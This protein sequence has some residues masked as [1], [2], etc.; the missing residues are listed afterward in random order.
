MNCKELTDILQHNVSYKPGV[1]FTFENAGDRI[2]AHMATPTEDARGPRRTVQGYT[3]VY[4]YAEHTTEHLHYFLREMVRRFELHEADEWLR[5]N[6]DLLH[7]PHA[8][9]VD[10]DP[11]DTRP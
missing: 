10:P 4:V 1:R 8:A 6:G 2:I 3:A 9:G 11:T 7:D 5:F